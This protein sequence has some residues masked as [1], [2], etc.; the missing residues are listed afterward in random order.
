MLK[1]RMIRKN[2]YWRFSNEDIAVS[3]YHEVEELGLPSFKEDVNVERGE[4][5]D[6]VFEDSLLN[7]VKFE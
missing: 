5:D 1:G 4:V 6:D 7:E 2:L 3:S